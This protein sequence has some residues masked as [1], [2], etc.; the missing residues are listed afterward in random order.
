MYRVV[1]GHVAA[2]VR[3]I[4]VLASCVVGSM[5]YA[6]SSAPAP[7]TVNGTNGALFQY[8][9]PGGLVG[10]ASAQAVCSIIGAA[11]SNPTETDTGSVV[12]N[13]TQATCTITAS[14]VGGQSFVSATVGL[15][16]VGQGLV[17]PQGANTVNGA[18][19][20]STGWATPDASACR[21]STNADCGTPG[22]ASMTASENDVF[23]TAAV[24]GGACVGGCKQ[25]GGSTACIGSS[26]F[27]TGP[28]MNTG[29]ACNS[30]QNETPAD[31]TA[32]SCAQHGQ[33][34]GTVNGVSVCAPATS[35]STST[36]ATKVSTSASGAT[37]TTTTTK[38]SVSNGDGTTTNTTTTSGPNGTST[39]TTTGPTSVLGTGPA[40]GGGSSG[41]SGGAAGSGPSTDFCASHPQSSI[42]ITSTFGG[43]CGAAFVCTG[44]AVQCAI[45]QDQHQRNCE[46]FEPAT[47]GG[48][49]ATQ[50]ATGAQ[51]VADGDHPSWS[52]S[53]AANV[54]SSTIDFASQIDQTNPFGSSCPV[55]QVLALGAPFG[56]VT[57]PF[58]TWCPSLQLIGQVVLGVCLLA[59]AF[60]VFGK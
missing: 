43:T 37:S 39:T 20:C 59:A 41:S 32:T 8:L 6:Q 40:A 18:C 28:Y 42:C 33:G 57:L 4:V 50:A 53:T 21:Q 36:S 25:K 27:V 47:A 49:L 51:A 44:D 38:D 45:A 16:Y 3:L 11:G 12:V 15:Q 31:P 13:G 48:D 30:S 35:S 52:P 5:G 10:P 1:G 17:C 24:G 23:P 58:S 9:G 54:A 34:V 14:P 55:D 26:C 7:G 2:V 60:I 22:S 46:F 56:S 29:Q 19:V